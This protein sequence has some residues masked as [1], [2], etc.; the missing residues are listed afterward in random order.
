M[1]RS[2]RTRFSLPEK[3]HLIVDSSLLDEEDLRNLLDYVAVL[4]EI[5]ETK[6]GHVEELYQGLSSADS[7]LYSA[8]R[9]GAKR[10][11]RKRQ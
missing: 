7:D 3:R 2:K 10:I 11:S 8:G 1:I 4:I 6:H 5:D 9:V